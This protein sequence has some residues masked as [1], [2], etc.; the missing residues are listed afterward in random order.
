MSNLAVVEQGS[1]IP[2]LA[3]DERELLATLES[4]LYPGAK[5]ASIKLVIAW[6]R[7]NRKDPFKRPVHIVPMSVK[8]AKGDY[9][10]RD[11]IMPGINDYRTDAMRTGAFAGLTSAEFG[12]DKTMTIS[13]VEITFPEWCEIKALRMLPNGSIAEFSSGKVR[14]LETYATA[15]RDSTAPNAMWKKRPYGQLEKCAESMAL[16]R[17]FPE[18]GSQNTAEEMEGRVVESVAEVEAPGKT[19]I[20]MPQRKPAAPKV[21]DVVDVEPHAATPPPAAAA[22]AP[23]SAPAPAPQAPP[24]A[25]PALATAGMK[26]YIKNKLG[27]ADPV[28]FAKEHGCDWEHLTL[29]GFQVLKEALA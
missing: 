29:D 11:V 9:E 24:A 6:C 15:K 13:G 2:A 10:W 25:A 1:T 17:A 16:R 28:E 14:W 18:I 3:M 8:S 12:P 5:E 23:A 19:E 22:P 20:Q 26:A 7:A 21:Q 4:S 27:N